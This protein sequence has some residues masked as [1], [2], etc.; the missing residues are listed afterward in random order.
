[1]M[2]SRDVI[3]QF[4]DQKVL[5]EAKITMMGHPF[6]ILS[7]EHYNRFNL[8]GQTLFYDTWL[9]SLFSERP[10]FAEISTKSAKHNDVTVK[11]MREN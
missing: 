6:C 1:M 4:Y 2:T 11:V 10:V 3:F 5:T 7:I 8:R 9:I